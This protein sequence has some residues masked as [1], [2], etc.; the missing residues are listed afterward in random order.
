MNPRT[1]RV[2][3]IIAAFLG[4]LVLCFGVALLV[5][6]RGA[7]PVSSQ[8]ADIGGSFHLTDQD[9]RTVSDQD[10]KGKP[11]LVFFGFTHCPD[12]CPTT[13]FDVSEVLRSLGP[14][15]DRVGA[16]FITVDPDRDTV[17]SMK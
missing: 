6:G 10:L 13:L 4:G 12:M 16:T 15:A 3:A 5:A 11:F 7:L 8:V 2:L 1:A 14:D 9:G 17:A